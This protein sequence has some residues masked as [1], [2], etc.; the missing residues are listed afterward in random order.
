MPSPQSNNPRP[1]AAVI[2]A[3]FGGL[4]A[5]IR[6]QARGYATTLFE[7]LPEPGGR[8]GVLR[9]RG[10]TFDTGPTVITAPFLIDEL[11]ALHGESR[12]ASLRIVPV[13]PFY[14]VLLP[15]GSTFNYHGGQERLEAEIARFNPRDVP[16]YRR[17]LRLT[18]RFCD[19]AFVD[20][21]DKPFTTL[22]DML[23]V[24]PELAW[25]RADRSA[26]RLVAR[27]IRDPRLRRVFSF[28]S[29]LIGGHPFRI[30][31]IYSM[32]HALERRWGMHY[33]MG[34]TTELVAAL[35]ALFSRMGGALRLNEG[36]RRIATDGRAVTG[37]DLENG[38]HWQGRVVVSNADTARTCTRLLAGAP[39]LAWPDDRILA[40]RQSMSLFLVYF[41]ASR[42]WPGIAHHTIILCNRYR[43]LLNDIFDRK[44]LPRDLSLY[45]HAPSVTDPAVAPP[46]HSAFYVLAPVPNNASEI[47]WTAEKDRYAEAVLD[48]LDPVLPGLR[49]HL[50]VR[51]IAT[52]DDFEHRLDSHLGN[53]FQFEPTLLQSAWFRPQNQFPDFDGLYLVG[54]GPQPRAR[55]PRVH[56]SAKVLDRVVPPA[57]PA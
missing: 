48:A 5:A 8:A 40:M 22:G 42:Q 38:G 15:D 41:G 56:C 28:N 52:P 30:S 44:L 12:P 3:G 16:G 53:G 49:A 35:A 19:R 23:R 14:R 2:G 47:N 10:Y 1:A 6:L 45:L 34:G 36:V 26:F 17:L 4:A 43:E 21:A 57:A 13:D 18:E 31:A 51:H 55:V 37:L 39:R 24:A 46:G 29:L 7:R 33:V 9:D 54:A 50:T 32:I 20:L 11:F 25:L 27:H